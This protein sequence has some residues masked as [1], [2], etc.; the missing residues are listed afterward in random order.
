MPVFVSNTHKT[1]K[2]PQEDL[3]TYVFGDLMIPD[4]CLEE[5]YRW[6]QKASRLSMKGTDGVLLV[7]DGHVELLKAGEIPRTY[8][9]HGVVN[10]SGEKKDNLFTMESVCVKKFSGLVI[11]PEEAADLLLSELEKGRRQGGMIIT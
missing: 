11:L 3:K 6:E 10:G 4:S 2:V 1:S 5:N 7:R 9:A 8:T